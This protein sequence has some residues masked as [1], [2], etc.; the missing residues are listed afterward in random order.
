MAPKKVIKEPIFN[1][2]DY[3]EMD[4]NKINTIVAENIDWYKCNFDTLQSKKWAL[5]WISRQDDLK[6]HLEDFEAMNHTWFGSKGFV[7]RMMD[8]GL[9]ADP[10]ITIENFK[11]NL[12]TYLKEKSIEDR[13]TDV[14]VAVGPKIR[15][16]KKDGEA[17]QFLDSLEG[18]IDQL[19]TKGSIHKASE[20]SLEALCRKIGKGAK[21][22]CKR[23]VEKE[24]KQMMKDEEWGFQNNERQFPAYFVKRAMKFYDQTLEWLKNECRS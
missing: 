15:V 18:C 8:N 16:P 17:D 22:T 9:K 14:E 4:Y 13:R 3:G 7:C 11:N 10:S 19:L 21:S 1:L 23:F 12:S 20:H 6:D 2:L 24:K 5:E